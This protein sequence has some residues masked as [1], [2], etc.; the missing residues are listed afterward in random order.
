[1][2]SRVTHVAPF[3]WESSWGWKV[4]DSLTHSPAVG[5]GCW[6]GQWESPLHD[7][8]MRLS[9]FSRTLDPKSSLAYSSVNPTSEVIS[10]SRLYQGSCITSSLCSCWWKCMEQSMS[11][12]NMSSWSCWEQCF[13]VPSPTSWPLMIMRI[14]TQSKYEGSSPPHL[15][16]KLVLCTSLLFH[17]LPC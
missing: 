1:M 11:Q 13:L 2:F 14:R 10:Y 15:S 9:P 4:R 8:F 7:L 17:S 6:L 3:S 12:N 5:A 16:L